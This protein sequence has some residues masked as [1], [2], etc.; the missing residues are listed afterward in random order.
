MARPM[1]AALRLLMQSIRESQY[2]LYAPRGLPPVQITKTEARFLVRRNWHTVLGIQQE[3][4]RLD[5]VPQ[6]PGQESPA[7][8]RAEAHSA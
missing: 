4:G 7:P 2:V 3:G 1:E 8:R 5:L 6:F